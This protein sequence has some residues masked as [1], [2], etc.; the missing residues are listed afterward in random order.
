MLDDETEDMLVGVFFNFVINDPVIRLVIDRIGLQNNLMNEFEL[1]MLEYQTQ[2]VHFLD[3]IFNFYQES[4][5]EDMKNFEYEYIS[6][7]FKDLSHLMQNDYFQNNKS[8]FIEV[9]NKTL[10]KQLFSK[11][12]YLCNDCMSISFLEGD[13]VV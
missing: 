11:D 8:W 10:K 2:F 9:W 12:S 7:F 5:P 6:L 4:L 3:T 13:G 1:F